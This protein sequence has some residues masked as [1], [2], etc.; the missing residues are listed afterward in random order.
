MDLLNQVQYLDE[1]VAFYF[2]L[3]HFA[4]HVSIYTPLQLVVIAASNVRA[5]SLTPTEENLRCSG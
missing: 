4:R 5:A 2:E 1:A 3:M